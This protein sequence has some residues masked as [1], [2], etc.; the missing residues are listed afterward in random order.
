MADTTTPQATQQKYNFSSSPS[1]LTPE[2]YQTIQKERED[3]EQKLLGA[4]NEFMFQHYTR[5]ARAMDATLEKTAKAKVILD[6]K[7]RRAKAK[8]RRDALKAA[9]ESGRKR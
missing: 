5:L 9:R 7:E 1:A 4:N 8:Q 6:K 3:I 2:D